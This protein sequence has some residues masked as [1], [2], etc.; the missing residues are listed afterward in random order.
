MKRARIR[1][2]LSASPVIFAKLLELHKDNPD[3]LEEKLHQPDD[4][5]PH[6]LHEIL[7]DRIAGDAVSFANN[8]FNAIVEYDSLSRLFKRKI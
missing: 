2:L 6:T 5:N 1:F 3:L 7:G 4:D 8:L